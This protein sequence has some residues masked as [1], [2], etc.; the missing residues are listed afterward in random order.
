MK[1]HNTGS[2]EKENVITVD[3]ANARDVATA[4]RTLRGVLARTPTTD[5][6]RH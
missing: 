2:P 5:A 3:D 4:I 1:A 6:H